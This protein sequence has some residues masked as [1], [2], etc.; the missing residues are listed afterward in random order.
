MYTKAT[1]CPPVSAPPPFISFRYILNDSP[2]QCSHIGTIFV[3]NVFGVFHD[4]RRFSEPFKF[5][6]ERF[7]NENAD[8]DPVNM[9]AFGY[10][11]RYVLPLHIPWKRLLTMKWVVLFR[12]CP[13][14]YVALN[15]AWLA[16]AQILAAFTIS[17]KRDENGKEKLSPPDFV[18]G[19]VV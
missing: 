3:P 12:I 15:S 5:K 4:E 17:P 7:L 14:R 19:L 13:G 18:S 6:P 9:G 2:S 16:I 1:T 8:F 11:R 10:G